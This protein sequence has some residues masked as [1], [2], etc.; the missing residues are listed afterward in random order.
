MTLENKRPEFYYIPFPPNHPF[1]GRQYKS[2]SP[3]WLRATSVGDL[4]SDVDWNMKCINIGAKSDAE[5]SKFWARHITS[6]LNGLPTMLDFRR[7]KPSGSIIMS[8]ESAEVQECENEL[9]FT[10]EPKMRIDVDASPTTTK[11]LTENFQSIAYHD[12]PLFLKMQ[13]VV[14]FILAAEWLNKK[15]IVFCPKWIKKNTTRQARGLKVAN[16]QDSHNIIPLPPIDRVIRP[17]SDVT[18]KTFEAEHW[19]WLSR[20][21][22][23]SCYGYDDGYERLICK[24]DGTVV[25]QQKCMRI[26]VVTNGQPQPVMLGIPLPPNVTPK[27]KQLLHL[28]RKQFPLPQ[29]FQQTITERLGPMTL[30]VSEVKNIKENGVQLD[31]TQSIHLSPDTP[32]LFN[33]TTTIRASVHDF[34]MLYKGM[35]PR[36]QIGRSKSGEAIIPDEESWSELYSGSVPWPKIWKV[37]FEGIGIPAASGGISTR[38]I[39][40]IQSEAIPSAVRGRETVSVHAQLMQ[41]GGS[42]TRHGS[43]CLSD[44]GFFSGS[45]SISGY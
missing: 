13:E 27:P 45:S 18:V 3:R 10:K 43:V 34:N 2:Y 9:V 29:S 1:F 37:P 6:Q 14:K 30:K 17:S 31:I 24:E 39:P 25:L 22:V 41:S 40:V 42:V 38:N 23:Q 20:H 5:K 21:G 15:G 26:V 36:S 12:E 19:R 16:N 35:D 11:Y 7:E 28:I 8:V 33:N 32:P 44:S 4:L